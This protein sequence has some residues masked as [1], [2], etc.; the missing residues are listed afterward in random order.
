MIVCH[1]QRN[2]QEIGNLIQAEILHIRKDEEGHS[3]DHECHLEKNIHKCGCYN[4]DEIFSNKFLI[5]VTKKN[6]TKKSNFA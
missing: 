6:S 3:I 1:D 5:E 2:P 4:T